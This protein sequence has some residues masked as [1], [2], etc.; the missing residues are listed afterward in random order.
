MSFKYIQAGKVMSDPKEMIRFLDVDGNL[1]NKDYNPSDAEKKELLDL[2][3]I[4]IRARQWDL[5][6]LTLQKTGRLGTFAPNL[7]EEACL[8][9]L[10]Y[11]LKKDDWFVPHYRVLAAQLA[12]GISE[13]NVFLYW[14]G[15]ELGS[16]FAKEL[17]TLPMQVVIGSQISIAAGVAYALKLKNGVHNQSIALATVGNGG[18]NEGEFHEGLNLASVRNLPFVLAAINNQWAISVPEHNSYKVLTLSQ[19][20]HSYDI[21]GIR[22]DGN[23]LLA[24]SAAVKE[25][26]QWAREGH[27][28]VLIE[29][30]T[31]RQG[32]HT[33]SDDPRVYRSREEEERHER[34][35][36]MH[37]IEKFLFDN[38]L[39]TEE[40][41][42]KL[43]EDAAAEARAAYDAS[44]LTLAKEG[45]EHVYDYTYAVL[46][47][48]LVAQKEANRRFLKK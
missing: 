33:T 46:P 7:G 37:R 47:E 35:E 8:S 28:P 29:F 41:K 22:V 34:W 31:W 10:G 4:M 32:Q 39:L 43:A 27:G 1:I 19:R 42:E 11:F 20:A 17:N 36:P 48:E 16:K 45:F 38:G 26:Y 13:E 12:R 21:P 24:C 25:A 9:A 5:Y 30:V 2:Y 3:K 23:D 40:V 15:S 18:T 6:A 44:T 14:R